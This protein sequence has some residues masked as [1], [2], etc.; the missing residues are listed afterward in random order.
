[1]VRFITRL[2]PDF[3]SGFAPLTC[4][5]ASMTS[6][7]QIIA[8]R[9]NALKSTGPRTELGKSF[10]SVNAVKHGLR[11]RQVV[12][13]GESQAEFDD[14]CRDLID[15]YAPS[16]PIEASLVDRIAVCLWRLRRTESIEAQVFD[17]LRQ[18]LKAASSD[19][20]PAP[21]QL[22]LPAES[23]TPNDVR[24]ET[25]LQIKQIFE[26]YLESKHDP[27]IASALKQMEA[28]IK[29]FKENPNTYYVA[30]ERRFLQFVRQ[31]F[32]GTEYL[33]DEEAAEIDEEIDYLLGLEAKA[34]K[35]DQ[36][37]LAHAVAAD[38]MANNVLSKLTRYETQ[39]QSG[40][41]KAMHELER[42]QKARHGGHVPPPNTL[43][44]D[45]T[46]NQ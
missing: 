23:P 38:V 46:N 14:F 27:K 31:E 20:P 5:H 21:L 2:R 33:S 35:E 37:N 17:N 29:Y 6:K 30:G 10:S 28:S 7:K 26:K 16:G 24:A 15:H 32:A 42:I 18:D 41:F 11:S 45:I 19:K 43:D 12:I 25:C 36:P 3:T 40:L 39:I 1:V 34:A 9:K 8:N 44:I 22:T 13:D 4:Y